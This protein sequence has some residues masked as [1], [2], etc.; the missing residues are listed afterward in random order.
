MSRRMMWIVFAIGCHQQSAPSVPPPGA[1]P[2]TQAP[3]DI[4]RGRYVATIAGCMAC[5]GKTLAGGKDEKLPNG[6][7][8]RSPNITPD[9]ATGIGM[10]TDD[11]ISAAIRQGVRPDH[12]RLIPIMPYPFYHRMTDADAKA[13]VAFL[14]V[15]PAVERRVARSEHVQM[16]PVE[17][18]PPIDNKDP[19]DDKRGHGAYLASLMHCA[20]CHGGDFAGGEAFE[21]AG[22]GEVVAANITSDPDTGVGKWSEQDI[23]LALRTMMNPHGLQIRPPMAYYI[24]AWSQLR[25]YDAISVA[26][27]VKTIPPVHRQIEGAHTVTQTP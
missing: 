17:L 12:K 1:M 27:F 24:D 7:V 25:D 21:V 3:S 5:H 4:D 14:R 2:V 23:V 6:G 11:E 16:Q 26:A 22:I 13:V 9:P 15:Q 10:W 20:A 19:V 18:A 8:W